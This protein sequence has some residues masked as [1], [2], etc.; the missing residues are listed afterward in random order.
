M[1]L[2]VICQ[3]LYSCNLLEN[4]AEWMDLHH[5]TPV[6]PLPK[7]SQKCVWHLAWIRI[8]ELKLR[9]CQNLDFLPDSRSHGWFSMTNCT[10]TFLL[11]KKSMKKWQVQ[12]NIN[13]SNFKSILHNLWRLR[14]SFSWIFL[15]FVRKLNFRKNNN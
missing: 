5:L 9:I 10:E 11:K 3:P 7:S 1:E 13:A 15:I 14:S 6:W 8:S 2:V 4:F 12:V